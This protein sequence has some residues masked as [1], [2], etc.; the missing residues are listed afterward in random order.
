[1]TYQ[2]PIYQ[3]IPL[4]A[5]SDPGGKIGAN[6]ALIQQSI[7]WPPYTV[8][9]R[10]FGAKG[11]GTTDDTTALQQAATAAA[12]GTL[13]IP[14]GTY[15]LKTGYVTV[16]SDTR[17]LL[18]A[19]AVLQQGFTDGTVTIPGET[20]G[21]PYSTTV[22]ALLYVAANATRVVIEGGR[23]LG[24]Y[25][26]GASGITSGIFVGSGTTEC[27]VRFLR[28]EHC[29]W[30]GV[31]LR[32][33]QHQ[34]DGLYVA[35]NATDGVECWGSQV[36][37]TGVLSGG[38]HGNAAFEAIAI[39]PGT[40]ADVTIADC[41]STG[42]DTTGVSST[43]GSM[44]GLTVIGC[45]VIGALQRAFDFTGVTDLVCTDNMG[46]HSDA[47]G[48]GGALGNMLDI[49][50]CP[51]F[52][53][54]NNVLDSDNGSGSGPAGLNIEGTSSGVV[55][56][57][58]ITGFWAGYACSAT[59]PVI[60]GSDVWSH[61]N[62]GTDGLI[63]ALTDAATVTVS[64][65]RGP[66]KTLTLGGNRTMGAPASPAT[67]QRL[68]FFITQDATGGRTLAWN[69]IYK[70]AWSD[71][72]NAA[73]KQSSIAFRYTGSVWQQEGAQVSYF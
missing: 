65:A 64:A 11:D 51:N 18:S 17:V 1:M 68:V 66:T 62:R 22:A 26:S 35:H 4:P 10:D 6:L 43:S 57:H 61:N 21:A 72:G 50:N 69:A 27:Q 73:G 48:S 38:G 39:S 30:S 36:V 34:V 16:Q 2:R 55:G 47:G 58:S 46:Q 19:G 37:V 33:S 31:I 52:V 29:W 23:L 12:G 42:G 20:L 44:T 63:D 67:G 24:T 5:N 25:T 15:L 28:A 3:R 59:G 40:A 54:A 9:V 49:N 60:L 8:D 53:V 13:Y 14:P 45:R 70:T 32:G 41:T 71:A 7:P 56:A